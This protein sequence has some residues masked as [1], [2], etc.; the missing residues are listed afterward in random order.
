MILNLYYKKL[1]SKYGPIITLKIGTTISIFISSHSLAYQSL[2]Q[3]GALCSDRPLELPTNLILSSKNRS[4]NTA[5][6]PTWRVLRRNLRAE[7]LRTTP[8]SKSRADWALNILIQKIIHKSDSKMGVI[9]LDHI[10]HAIFIGKLIFRNRWKEVIAIRKEVEIIFIPLIEARIKYKVERANSEVHQEEEIVRAEENHDKSITEDLMKL[11]YLKA[12]ILEGIR[13]H[14]PSHFLLPHR[15]TEEMELNGYALPKNAI[16][17]F[18]AREMGLDPNVW[19]DPMEFKPERFLVD[20]ETFDITGSRE[21]KMMPFGV[22]RRICPG[23]DFAMFHLE[24][25]VANLIWH[26]EWKPVEGDDVDLTER[27]DFIFTMKNPLRAR[28]SPR[29]N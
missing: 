1:I 16:I 21:T 11:S 25:F 17:Y 4:I 23:Y 27:L 24:Y 26:F 13:R 20:R 15:V 22:G 5:Y 3:H 29:L 14:P 9:L 28:I 7:M 18:M 10:K 12:V 6:G 2:I 19:K 8:R